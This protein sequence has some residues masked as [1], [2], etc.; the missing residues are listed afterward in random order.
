MS[1]F[2]AGLHDV[3][4][5]LRAISPSGVIAISNLPDLTKLPRFQDNPDR[6]VTEARVQ[7]YNAAIARQATK[8]NVLLVDLYSVPLQDS[9]VN[10]IDG[11]HPSDAGH[12]AIA[13][14]F[15]AVLRPYIPSLD[16]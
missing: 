8:S 12:Q 5:E 11:F 2:E 13:N 7:A 14:A 10:D 15:L 1:S 16:G 4:V 6:D 9:F 3:L